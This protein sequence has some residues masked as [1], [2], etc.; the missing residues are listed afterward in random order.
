MDGILSIIG[1]YKSAVTKPARRLGFEW[2]WQSRFHDRI[3]RDKQSYL[4]IGE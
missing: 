4:R 3:I 1:S 2:F